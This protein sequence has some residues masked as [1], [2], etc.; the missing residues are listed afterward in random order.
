MNNELSNAFILHQRPYRE[1]SLLLDVFSEQYGRLSLI[2]KGVRKT[3]R[4]QAVNLQLYQ[5]LLLSWFGHGELQTITQI[6]CVEARY[7]LQAESA[8]CGLYINELL[9][10]LLPLHD[11]E[12]DIFAIYKQT[13]IKLQQ[14]DDNEVAL[15]LFEKKLLDHLGYGLVI[16][17]ESETGQAIQADQQYYYHIELGL[18][19]WQQDQGQLP[20]SGRSLQHL[21]SEQGFDQQSLLEIK[22][23]MRT[24]IHFYLGG[25]PLKSRQVFVE[26]NK[27]TS[28]KS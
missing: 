6:E 18:V 8:L 7:I 22:Q 26:M 9:L 11:A 25:K 5:P 21:S 12:A 4:N 16:D 20:I 17:C 2:A 14:A 19:R 1:S 3:K 13:L 28:I 27:Y 15:R 10:R 23:L 24:V